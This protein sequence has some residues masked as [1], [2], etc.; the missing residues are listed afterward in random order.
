MDFDVIEQK[1]LQ[2]A[3]QNIWNGTALLDMVTIVWLHWKS[4]R[5]LSRFSRRGS[6]DLKEIERIL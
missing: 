5:I 4:L 6:R 2:W 1:V 3:L